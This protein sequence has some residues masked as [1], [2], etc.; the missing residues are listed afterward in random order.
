MSR[1]RRAISSRPAIRGTRHVLEAAGRTPSVRRVVLTSSIVAVYGDAADLEDIGADRFDESHWNSTSNE[2][3]QPYSHSKTLAERLAWE[4]AGAQDRWDLVVVNP[5]LVLGPG[6]SPHTKA[7]GVLIMLDFGNGYYAFGAPEL[8]FAIVDVR[9]VAEAHLRAGM[10]P[11]ASGRHILVSESLSVM[12]IAEVLRDHFGDGYPFPRHTVSRAVA[13]M[14]AP[15]RGIPQAVA[16]RNLGYPLRFDNRR[17]REALGMTFRPAAESVVE[18][19]RQ[20][21]DDG[22]GGVGGTGAVRRRPHAAASGNLRLNPGP[23][24]P[25]TPPPRAP[26][27]VPVPSKTIPPSERRTI[28][29]VTGRRISIGPAGKRLPH[30]PISRISS[31]T[32]FPKAPTILLI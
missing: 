17:A 30:H 18:H 28:L 7:E 26:R 32:L 13:L 31:S 25:S 19:F 5:G 4:M 10:M 9:D 20:L 21:L 23:D 15:K 12:D 29:Y 6:L 2:R 22:L 1:I 16:R 24:L 14:L 11:E 3:H 8:E 27:A